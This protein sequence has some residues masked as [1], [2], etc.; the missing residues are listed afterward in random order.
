[1]FTHTDETLGKRVRELRAT[2]GLSQAK[3]GA[4]LGVTFQQIQK[5]ERGV[6]RISV[7]SLYPIAEALGVTVYELLQEPVVEIETKTH[8]ALASNF[9]RIRSAKAQKAVQ[10]LILALG[11]E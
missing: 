8:L 7:C 3:L 10:A 6:N 5:Y 1:M 2:A 11:G 9:N 4:A